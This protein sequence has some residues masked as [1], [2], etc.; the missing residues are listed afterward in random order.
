MSNENSD[1]RRDLVTG[2]TGMLGSHIAEQLARSGW[3][4]CA[5]IRPGSDG[6]FLRTLGVKLIEGD[7]TDPASCLRATQGVRTVYHAAAKVGDWGPWREFRAGC[8]EATRNL[9]N[10]VLSNGAKR[11]LHISSTS[12]YGHPPDG[13]PPIDE[14]AP[15]GQNIWFR[16]PYTRSKVESEKLLWTLAKS[17]GKPL[18]II[19]P[20]WLYGERDRTTTARLIERLRRGHVPLVGT[21]EN[22]LSAI[23]VG[24]VAEAAIRAANDPASVGEAYN[25]TDQGPIS[26][27]EFM[28]LFAAACHAPAQQTTRPYGIVYTAAAL[29]EVYGQLIRS[30]RPPLITRY[31]TWLL[32]RNLKY[33]TEKARR[34]LGW[35]PRLTYKECIERTVAWFDRHPKIAAD[36]DPIEP[37]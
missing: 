3:R 34:R 24:L 27:R 36:R 2:G 12:A 1:S 10:A 30:R 16:D 18:T 4:V 14:T 8:I 22:P 37:D 28:S 26:Q 19:R 33:S 11:F 17:P 13:S 6:R 25:I 15:L 7:L 31:A 29:L 35:T 5:L 32:G 9:A 23:Y 20:S 21:G